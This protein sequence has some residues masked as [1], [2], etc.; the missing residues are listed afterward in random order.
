MVAPLAVVASPASAIGFTVNSNGDGGDLL[1]GNGTC[2]TL[3]N[4]CTLR[5]AVQEANAPGALMSSPCRLRPSA[6][7]ALTFLQQCDC[8]GRG[9]PHHD[10]AGHW[11]SSRDAGRSSGS[12][13]QRFHGHRRHRDRGPSGFRRAAVTSRSTGALHRQRCVDR[14]GG[15][16]PVYSTGGTMDLRNSRS[17]A[18]PRRVRRPTAGVAALRSI[19]RP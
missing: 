5:A 14:W 10:P 8:A 7:I 15:Y 11:R 3:T 12:S 9:R 2:A 19:A 17:A 16:G 18:T 4:V 13:P 6:L 1:P